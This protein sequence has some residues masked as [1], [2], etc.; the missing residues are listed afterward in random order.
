ME[1][2]LPEY[3]ERGQTAYHLAN[4]DSLPEN[5]KVAKSYVARDNNDPKE[6]KLADGYRCFKSHNAH[7]P[8]VFRTPEE[9]EA[10]IV[11]ECWQHKAWQQTREGRIEK[12]AL[13]HLDNLETLCGIY[14][15]DDEQ[16]VTGVTVSAIFDA[17]AATY[18]M[19]V[20]DA[21][22]R[23]K[24]KRD[25]ANVEGSAIRSKCLTVVGAQP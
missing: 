12:V 11:A 2:Q 20:R 22:A 13:K 7:Y 5:W 9:A 24:A 16:E 25:R 18:N 15:A 14:R 10:R 19:G 6:P 17:V 4:T 23:A 8:N 21:N 1:D 3:W